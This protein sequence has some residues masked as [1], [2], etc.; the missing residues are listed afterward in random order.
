MKYDL[1]RLGIDALNA[2]QQEVMQQYRRHRHL[3]LLSPTG[4]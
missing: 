2:M 3:V 1:S 4:L